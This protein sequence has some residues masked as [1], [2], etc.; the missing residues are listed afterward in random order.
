MMA[1]EYA[2][3]WYA[4]MQQGQPLQFSV[5]PNLFRQNLNN[6]MVTSIT[7]LMILTPTGEGVAD[8]PTLTLMIPGKASLDMTLQKDPTK[9]ILTASIGGLTLN[10]SSVTE[11]QIVVKSDSDKLISTANVRNMVM[12]LQYTAKFS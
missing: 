7:L 3:A 11:W 9:E 10:V 6:Y 4:F 8:M 2:G 1:Q 12:S 5:G